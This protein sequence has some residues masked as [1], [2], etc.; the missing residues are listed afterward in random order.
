MWGDTELIIVQIYTYTWSQ[1]QRRKRLGTAH[2]GVT[3]DGVILDIVL[4]RETLLE[5]SLQDLVMV[6]CQ[7]QQGSSSQQGTPG[8]RRTRLLC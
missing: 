4:W 3:G 2:D 1:M 7:G 6:L 5:I 8:V